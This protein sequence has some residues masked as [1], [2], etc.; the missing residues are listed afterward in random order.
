MHAVDHPFPGVGCQFHNA[1]IHPN[2]IFRTRLDAETTHYAHADVDIEYSRH[3][4]D[5]RIWMFR[6][7]D[8]DAARRTK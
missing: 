3:L 5:V 2:G 7:N 8:M 6:R 4:L 1:G